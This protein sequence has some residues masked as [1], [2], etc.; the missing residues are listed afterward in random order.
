MMPSSSSL[1]KDQ[2]F[3]RILPK[4]KNNTRKLPRDQKKVNDAI[5]E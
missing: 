3:E 2:E 1:K 5:I 4:K